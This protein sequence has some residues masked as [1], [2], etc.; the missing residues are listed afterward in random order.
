MT[1]EYASPEQVRGEPIT[2]ASDVYSLGVRALRAAHRAAAVRRASGSLDE[3]VRAVCETRAAEPSARRASRRPPRRRLRRASCAGD[4]DTIVLKA[5]RKEPAAALPVGAGARGRPPALPRRPAGPGA[6]RH[7]R[8]P[9]G[10]VRAP[11]PGRRGA[12]VLVVAASWRDGGGGAPGAHRG[13]ERPRAERRFDDV[14]RLA[15]AVL[16]DF[17]DAIKL[18][19]DARPGDRGP[20]RARIPRHPGQEAHDDPSLQ[21]ELAGLQA[22]G[23]LQ[24]SARCGEP[25]PDPGGPAA[26]TASRSSTAL[27]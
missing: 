24:G 22:V 7:V 14:R 20:P 6:A 4:L 10:K 8:L 27:A 19:G 17:H 26:A 21:R 25:R 11:A 16:F 12:A 2:T 1:P 9:A 13:G 23:D 3:I 15:N 5:L 18:P